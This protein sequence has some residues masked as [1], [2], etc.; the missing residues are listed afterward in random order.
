MNSSYENTM[1]VATTSKTLNNILVSVAKPLKIN[2]YN[3]KNRT[4]LIAVPSFIVV[5][6]KKVFSNKENVLYLKEVAKYSNVNEWQ[7]WYWGE[8]K[9]DLP[10][11]LKRHSV[12]INKEKNLSELLKKRIAILNKSNQPA[13]IKTR[14]E[15]IIAIYLELNK[16]KSLKETDL[17]ETFQIHKR[18]LQ[19][20]IQLLKG[21]KVPIYFDGSDKKYKLY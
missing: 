4:D 11:T 1:L 6:D 14:V 5:T 7:I 15:R 21:L 9:A 20:D 3:L 16:K 12:L 2:L 13:K 10:S 18:T 17:C 19:R 8:T